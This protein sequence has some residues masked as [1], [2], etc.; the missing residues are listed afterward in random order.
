RDLFCGDGGASNEG[1][2]VGGAAPEELAVSLGEGQRLSPGRV[3]G[4][5]VGVAHQRQLGCA[6]ATL[7]EQVRFFDPALVEVAVAFTM[8]ASSGQTW[9]ENVEQRRV[10]PGRRG[11]DRH[12]LG[13]QRL[14]LAHRGRR[15]WQRNSLVVQTHGA[16]V[17]VTVRCEGEET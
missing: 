2:G 1:F 9:L 12:Q 16:P 13:E 3:E 17:E 6:L 4:N 7:C 8:K 11:V 15:F 10:R 14:E 5:A